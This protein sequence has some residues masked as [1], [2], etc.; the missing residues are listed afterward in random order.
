MR[1]QLWFCVWLVIALGAGHIYGDPGRGFATRGKSSGWFGG[2]FSSSSRSKPQTVKSNSPPSAMTKPDPPP[3]GWNVNNNN[4]LPPSGPPPAYPGL[5]S[6]ATKAG[7]G[8]VPPPRPPPPYSSLDQS[9][10]GMKTPPPRP[11]P[12]Y[13][14]LDQSPP[15]A[16][17]PPVAQPPVV[18]PVPSAPLTIVN[19][20]PAAAPSSSLFGGG[21]LSNMLFYGLGSMNSGSQ[22][23]TI[24]HYHNSSTTLNP[25]Q[26]IPGTPAVAEGV[27][28]TLP[29]GTT[30]T[31]SSLLNKL[32]I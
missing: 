5:E 22:T 1:H 24:H 21:W 26:T 6:V 31:E 12:P 25:T 11:P 4:K 9:P 10:T 16:Y 20:Y 32:K 27:F 18:Q 3:I 30:T 14:S 2:F 28:A 17:S 15:P 13:S 29:N 7:S 19:A 8:K 23:Q